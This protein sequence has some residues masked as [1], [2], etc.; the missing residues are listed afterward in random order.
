MSK[1]GLPLDLK[2]RHD[3]HY[4]EEL[5]QPNRTVGRIISIDLLEP[6][7]EQPRSEFGDLSELTSSIKEHGVLEP[8][9]VRQIDR[10]DR[11][12]I[13]AGER[14]WRAANLAGLTEV[15]C[16]ELN[17][18]DES[19]AEIALVENLQR[20]DLTIWEE[21]DGL[22]LLAS[23]FGYTHDKI[24]QT[25]G[26]SRSTVTEYMSIAGIPQ[27]VREKCRV[28]NITAK[29]SLLEVARQ[30][31]DAAMI[32]FVESLGQD[33]LS[34]EEIRRKVR[35]E[36]KP[37]KPSVEN[38]GSNP[39]AVIPISTPT[40]VEVPADPG[41]TKFTY[42]SETNGFV[43]EIVFNHD[44]RLE[45]KEVLQALKEAFDHVKAGR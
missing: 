8:L 6:N 30:F 21:A 35:P 15:P 28:A 7:P 36:T 13:I 33:G 31:D 10:T 11:F 44:E 43:V 20:K 34:R 29:T 25:I 1:R 26:K 5:A 37:R 24:S 18:S 3:L 16:I 27:E 9:L 38:P 14:R 42:E 40:D 39:G 32:E 17:I 2:P 4:I 45:R 22:A 19:V 23:K 12:M 41:G